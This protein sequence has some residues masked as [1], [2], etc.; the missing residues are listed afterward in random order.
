[1]IICACT[2]CFDRK[3]RKSTNEFYS[4][5]FCKS[6]WTKWEKGGVHS[7]HV[8]TA[9]GG[10][11][12]QLHFPSNRGRNEKRT[13]RKKRGKKQWIQGWK[14]IKDFVSICLSW[15]RLGNLISGQAL[16]R[17]ASLAHSLS[18][19]P[20]TP[21]G[22]WMHSLPLPLGFEA[23]VCVC[24]C[25]LFLKRGFMTEINVCSQGREGSRAQ[26]DQHP[27]SI[28]L[29][30]LYPPPWSLSLLLFISVCLSGFLSLPV[31]AEHLPD[32]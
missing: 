11:Y 30:I 23:S 22:R 2:D 17:D 8:Q 14:T 31:V 10:K 29:I 16:R 7:N 4:L 9:D 13:G 18:A 25:V 6:P 24:V 32:L 3:H 28:S 20:K 15:G 26:P 1:M 19:H 5:L 27:E 21:S 12:P